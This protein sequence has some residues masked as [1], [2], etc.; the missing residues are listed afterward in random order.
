MAAD[1]PAGDIVVPTQM[2]FSLRCRMASLY[3]DGLRRPGR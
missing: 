1:Q 2:P 3:G